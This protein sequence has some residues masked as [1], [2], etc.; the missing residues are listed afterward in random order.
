MTVQS[1]LCW[2]WSEARLSVFSSEGSYECML[3]VLDLDNCPLLKTP[4]KEIRDKGFQSI[5][6]YL[7]RLLSGALLSKRTKLMLVG[8]GGAGKTR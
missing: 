1:G 2:T 4:P 3:S 5:L 7:Q 8:L 6:A